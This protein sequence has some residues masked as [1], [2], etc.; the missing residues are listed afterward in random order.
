MNLPL[1]LPRPARRA[2]LPLLTAALLGGAAAVSAC[3][4][5]VFRYALDHWESDR[6]RLEVPP[7]AAKDPEVATFLRNLGANSPVNLEARPTRESEA[8][9]TFP[10]SEVP[11]WTGAFTAAEQR[12]LAD[13]PARHELVRRILSGDSAVWVLVEGTPASDDVAQRVERRLRLL[14]QVAELPKIDPRDPDSQ[15][16]PGPELKLHFSLLRVQANDPAEAAFIRMLAGPAA[17]DPAA[18][19]ATPA[20]ALVFGRA[21][22]LRSA[23]AAELGDA[24]IEEMSLFLLGACS[25]RVKRENPGWDLLTNVKWE[26]ALAQAAKGESQPAGASKT[27]STAPE[28]N[29]ATTSTSSREKILGEKTTTVARPHPAATTADA[30]PTAT[31]TAPITSSPGP[32][33]P[34]AP[35]ATTPQPASPLALPET[36][37][38][39][40]SPAPPQAEEPKPTRG[41]KAA[42]LGTA[43]LLFGLIMALALQAK[44]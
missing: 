24:E 20:L 44:R 11:L 27:S 31:D 13:S 36:V 38:I 2:F 8:R 3:Q 42:L 22:V 16:G 14:E 19:T 23:P 9:L 33:T 10:S 5:P 41:R 26:E 29:P 39:E 28:A 18:F 7:A 21:R 25:C 32:G 37:K 15:L 34:P 30:A 4:V 1:Y 35:A 40:P 17:K 43:T 6:Y 12:T